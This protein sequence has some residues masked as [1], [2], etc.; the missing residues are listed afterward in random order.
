MGLLLD[1]KEDL[2]RFS[3]YKDDFHQSRLSCFVFFSFALSLI[4]T[5]NGNVQ[6]VKR[7]LTS[8]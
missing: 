8:G 1:I 6:F 3:K 4:S 5:P 7:L 2:N